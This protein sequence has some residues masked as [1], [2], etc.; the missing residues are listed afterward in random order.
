MR[1]LSERR[2]ILRLFTGNQQPG[3]HKP[4][5]KGNIPHVVIRLSIHGVLQGSSGLTGELPD[6]AVKPMLQRLF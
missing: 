4:E 1:R 2:V 5:Q 3:P 6:S